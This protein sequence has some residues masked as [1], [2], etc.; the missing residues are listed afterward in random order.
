MIR[1]EFNIQ[2]Y[3]KVI[4]LYNVTPSLYGIIFR[5]L[6]SKGFDADLVEEMLS[7][8]GKD[9]KAC[10][11]SDL[12]KHFSFVLINQHDKKPDL[13]NS[14]VH[15][16]EHIKQAILEAYSVPDRG[17]APAYTLGYIV[18]K[19]WKVARTLICS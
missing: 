19:M 14:V 18:A 5:E 12:S 13:V 9:G 7:S 10:T 2:H 8:L 1:Q 11:C 16:A 4:V 17:E 3:W 15:E 6:T